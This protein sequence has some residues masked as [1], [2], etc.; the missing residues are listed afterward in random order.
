M[1]LYV[2]NGKEVGNPSYEVKLRWLD[3]FNAHVGSTWDPAGSMLVCGDYNIAPDDRDVWD[4]ESWRGKNLAS[5]QERDMVR[6]LIAR[7]IVDMV[8][9]S[10]MSTLGY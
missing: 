6:T 1:N 8:R 9:S 7:D 5:E 10:T 4:R 2:V 3:A